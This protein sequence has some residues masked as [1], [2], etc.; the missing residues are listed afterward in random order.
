M[1][2]KLLLTCLSFICITA[3]IQADYITLNA[4]NIWWFAYAP[5][6]ARLASGARTG[7]TPG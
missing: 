1:T 3:P 4:F 7:G 6:T 2:M 5:S